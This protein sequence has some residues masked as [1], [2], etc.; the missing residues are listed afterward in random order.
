MP[1]AL[2]Y[3]LVFELHYLTTDNMDRPVVRTHRRWNCTNSAA[4]RSLYEILDNGEL[5][6]VRPV[7]RPALLARLAELTDDLQ[8][9]T[10]AARELTDTEARE[11]IFTITGRTYPEYCSR[12]SCGAPVPIGAARC[13]EWDS[14]GQV[15]NGGLSGV[16]RRPPIILRTGGDQ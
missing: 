6:L 14:I 3:L 5:T 10:G 2:R 15:G 12:A 8:R 9:L 1:A 11:H 7:T 13:G 4:P 16:R